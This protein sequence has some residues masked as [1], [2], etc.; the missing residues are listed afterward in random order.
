MM[1]PR[2]VGV[3]LSPLETTMNCHV[4]PHMW[5]LRAL[6]P[7]KVNSLLLRRA[8]V[9]STRAGVVVCDSE[10]AWPRRVEAG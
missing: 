3:K 2:C 8:G 1:T 9:R 6:I 5:L 7:P 4:S 10:A